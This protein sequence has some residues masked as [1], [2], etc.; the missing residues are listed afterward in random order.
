MASGAH[1]RARFEGG[2][3]IPI[4]NE[5]MTGRSD[6]REPVKNDFDNEPRRRY[7]KRTQER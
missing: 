4:N 5:K 3:V 6:H 7:A 1:C 2:R